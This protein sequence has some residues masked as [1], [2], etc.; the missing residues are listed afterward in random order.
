MKKTSERT[1]CFKRLFQSFRGDG[2]ELGTV[3]EVCVILPVCDVLECMVSACHDVL[4]VCMW[5]SMACVR[6]MCLC[7]KLGICVS[8]LCVCSFNLA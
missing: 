3:L 2:I 1:K 7:F 4:E 6:S 5:F 8:S